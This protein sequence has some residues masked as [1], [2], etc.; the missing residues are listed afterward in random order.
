MCI[1]EEYER[2]RRQFRVHGGLFDD[3]TPHLLEETKKIT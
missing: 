3:T 2:I 1:D